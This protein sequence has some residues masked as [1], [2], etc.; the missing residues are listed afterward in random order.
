MTLQQPLPSFARQAWRVSYL[1]VENKAVTVHPQLSLKKESLMSC[2]LRVLDFTT[3]SYFCAEL[4]CNTKALTTLLSLAQKASCWLLPLSSP[5]MESWL[6]A[7]RKRQI[8]E[9][10]IWFWF[11][12]AW[13]LAFCSRFL[14]LVQAT[15]SLIDPLFG[16]L[17]HCER[18]DL[19][20]QSSSSETNS[21]PL[22]NN[23]SLLQSCIDLFKNWEV[24]L[25]KCD[26]SINCTQ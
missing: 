15:K 12:T 21:L 9:C 26:K 6:Q 14:A 24:L 20:Y 7:C 13:M 23:V 2:S 22:Q 5:Q 25:W 11:F 18:Q 8:A 19:N 3:A 17:L 4:E 16:N 1:S 10:V